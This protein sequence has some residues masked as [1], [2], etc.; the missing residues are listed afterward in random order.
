MNE[1]QKLAIRALNQMR[2]NDADSAE[3]DA[4][5]DWVEQQDEGEYEEDTAPDMMT[6]A[7]QKTLMYASHILAIC[8]G[9]SA[10]AI[11]LKEGYEFD[12]QHTEA[13]VRPFELCG[14]GH[15]PGG[16]PIAFKQVNETTMG[17]DAIRFYGIFGWVYGCVVLNEAGLI[18]YLPITAHCDGGDL[19]IISN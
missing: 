11:L 5:I 1:Y 15:P 2:G 7:P 19:T 13:D 17:L 14:G 12:E 4:A 10:R 16:V 3:I 9:G 18:A 8:Q 6:T